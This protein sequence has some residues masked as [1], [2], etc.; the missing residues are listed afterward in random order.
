VTTL[1]RL[2]NAKVQ[3]FADDHAPPHF[4]LYGPDANA[5]VEISTMRV[6]RGAIS[7]RDLAEAVAWAETNREL[8]A[9]EWRR[10]NERE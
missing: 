8:L 9:A 5:V 4:H 1:A 10:L 3:M 7:R 6:L 2:S